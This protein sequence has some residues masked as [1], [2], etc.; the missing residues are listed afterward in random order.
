MVN[1]KICKLTL[2][3]AIG[4]VTFVP[5]AAFATN[6]YFSHGVSTKEKG[7]VGAG[8]AYSQDTLA[9]GTNP[10]GMVWQGNRWDAGAS[11]FSP[12]REYTADGSPPGG[13][14]AANVG[15]GGPNDTVN[16]EMED[17]I[18]PQFGWNKMLDADSAFGVSVF[19]RGGMN[20]TWKAKDTAGG[21]GV[22]GSPAGA[23]GDAGVDLGQ[24]FIMP[25]YSR[26]ISNTSSWGVS[27]IV[28]YQTFK[29]KGI[30][31][32]S[33]ISI[34]PANLTNNDDDTSVGLGFAAGWQ[35]EVAPGWTLGVSYQSEIK[36]DEFDDYAGLFAEQGD[37]DIPSTWIVGLAWD[38]TPKSKLVVDV[39]K[40]NYT[41]VPSVSNPSLAR[42]VAPGCAPGAGPG[43]SG[44]GPGCLGADDGVGFGWDDMTVFKIGYEW[45]TSPDWTWRVGFSDADQ[46]IDEDADI[47]FNVLAPGVME[48]HF[49]F[50]FT[51]KLGS[52]TELNFAAMYAPE[53]CIE[54]LSNPIP[55]LGGGPG[56]QTTELCMDQF[57]AALSYG[58][59]F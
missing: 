15:A 35:G 10:A 24:L 2:A 19:G 58:K 16:S 46:P 34:D 40:I 26:K 5:A 12:M 8:A 39:Q 14:F 4:L 25:T 28:A 3:S 55:V 47:L 22:F 44:A 53:E 27:A 1:R 41:D 50:G 43:G 37:F 7:L 17:F 13:P 45:A 59:R 6:G 29:A 21:F 31:N 9:A 56:T 54:G 57:E 49:T 11:W 36:M 30:V 33:G 20:T 32:F 42:L 23:G 18:I 52:N 38:V 48:D 51:R